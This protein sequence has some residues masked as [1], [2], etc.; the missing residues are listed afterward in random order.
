MLPRPARLLKQHHLISSPTAR[1]LPF[2]VVSSLYPLRCFSASSVSAARTIRRGA[3]QSAGARAHR[4]T[5]DGQI[6]LPADRRGGRDFPEIDQSYDEYMEDISLQTRGLRLSEGSSK[7][8]PRPRHFR[9]PRAELQVEV[10]RPDGPSSSR[11][12][13]SRPKSS[14][15]YGIILN[16]SE[17][18]ED[19]TSRKQEEEDEEEEEDLQLDRLEVGLLVRKSRSATLGSKRIGTV[20]LPHELEVGIDSLIEGMF[21]RFLMWISTLSW[22]IAR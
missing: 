10:E 18:Q 20:V 14:K 6:I 12:V 7:A 4:V 16:A 8:S 9:S 5:F 17:S 1:R 3:V 19:T 2:H 13:R 15:P 21:A 11:S 22:S